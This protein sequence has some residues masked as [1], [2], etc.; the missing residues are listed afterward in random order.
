MGFRR[1]LC[2]HCKRKLEAGQKLH[3]HCIDAYAEAEGAKA[4]RKRQKQVRAAAKVQRAQDRQLRE[5]QKR[6]VDLKKEAQ[7]EF[8]AF[9]RHRDKDKGCFVC[10]TPFP[11]NQHG[12]AFDAGHVRSCGAADHLRFNEDNCHGECKSC[13]SSW[14]AKPHELEAGAIQRIGRERYEA[15]ATNN[16]RHK[17]T[18]DELRSIRDH[19]RA[20]NKQAK[21]E[22]TC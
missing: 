19:Y 13:N 2:P 1:T 21:K 3:P 8:N 6:I 15:L 12:G 4:E 10:G 20:L 22:P 9:I 7:Y 5:A 17:W 18:H 11:G 16:A 14:G